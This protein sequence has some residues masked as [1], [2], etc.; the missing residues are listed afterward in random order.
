[1]RASIEGDNVLKRPFSK[2]ALGA[3]GLL[4]FLISGFAGLIYQSIWSQYLGLYL[5]HA[6]YAQCLV[7]AIFMG[8]MA[9]GAWWISRVGHSWRNLLR[10]YAGAELLIGL[11]AWGFNGEYQL[12]T[13]FAY[14]HA[15]PFLAST[16]AVN[17]FKWGSGALL[18]LPQS[19][20][21]GM[22]FPLMSGALMRRLSSKEGSILSGLYF[23]NSMGAAIGALAATFLL[24]PALGLP[25]TIRIGAMLNVA[26]AAVAWIL[27]AGSGAAPLTPTPGV[28]E[29][30]KHD[31][32]RIML[33]AAFI[34]GATS[35]VYEIGWIRML[36][37]ALGT[38]IHSFELMLTAFIVGLAFGGLWIRRRIDSYRDPVAVGGY[39]QVL[40][41]MAALGS[42]FLY[43]RSFGWV[44]WFMHA[45]S[46]DDSGY[47]LYNVV[48]AVI[49]ILIMMPAAFFAGM[50]LPLFTL[51][52]IRR[53]G[54]EASIGRIYAADTLGAIV[55][56]FV[57]MYLLIPDFG[58]KLAIVAGAGGDILLGL[59]LLRSA[60]KQDRLR[61][62]YATMATAFIAVALALVFVRF[63]LGSLSAGVYRTGKAGIDRGNERVIYYR[64]GR[65]STVSVI[66]YRE[67]ARVISTNGKPDASIEMNPGNSPTD[68]EITMV[69][70]GALP[71]GYSR[72]PEE[73]ANIGFGS[74]LTTQTLLS[75][76]RVRDVDSIEIE[77][78]MYEGAKAFI[79]VVDKAY[80][81]PRS[82]IYFDDAKT[83]FAARRKRYDV[84]VSEPSN[85]W[86]TG[87]ATLFS[88][89]FYS[90]VPRYLNRG[91]IFVQWMQLYE[92]DDA[93]V[94]TVINSLNAE[95]K[96]YR[97]Y[98]TDDQDM[99][100]VASADGRL[101]EMQADV[102]DAPG[103]RSLL[104]RV[105]LTGVADF[106]FHELGD[107][108]SMSPLAATL[109]NR[110]NSDFYPVLSLEAPRTRFERRAAYAFAGLPLADLPYIESLGKVGP[111]DPGEVTYNPAYRR[112]RLFADAVSVVSHLTG[113][114]GQTGGSPA[115]DQDAMLARDLGRCETALDASTGTDLLLRLAGET[116]PYLPAR[117][118][119]GVWIH[120]NWWHCAA[121]VAQIR[122]TMVLLDEFA[123]RD[124]S[125]G[126]QAQLILR[127][128]RSQLSNY[129][130]DYLLRIAMLSA[131]QQRDYGQVRTLDQQLGVDIKP[132]DATETQRA[133]LIA[134]ADWALAATKPD[135]A[136]SIH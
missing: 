95:F 25:G 53:G 114:G 102:L 56:V 84:I 63:D 108:D 45:L 57:A 42:L 49:A 61:P 15:F 94:A 122:E 10:A 111:F 105:G 90:Y 13:D 4:L 35:F 88:R 109:S 54:G 38:T 82:H 21:L 40:M 33:I 78:A 8:G 86:V 7:L 66:E 113:H 115:V 30:G 130:A 80:T 41:G 43:T 9:A 51:V 107:K 58:L 76:P 48:T 93:L 24:L 133:Y 132:N 3:G 67:G 75:D 135:H 55:G 77:P 6:A 119:Q 52:M 65:T 29:S 1:M 46:R 62:Y 116:I 96:D 22:T 16:W 118:M 103:L 17:A 81:D 123:R 32:Q 85:P 120:P 98:L 99:V 69:M 31:G 128:Y 97:I 126:G 87:V 2:Q 37:L 129:A 79:P 112:T 101:P 26:I 18:M 60:Q 92:I 27:S 100:V 59:V 72:N 134:Y 28:L 83:Y 106:R 5:G 20:L 125:A 34:T 64:D 50:T 11:M 74:G 117:A 39:V 14:N 121:P 12:I 104:T 110:S 124:A 71:L 91:G 44:E 70:A 131:I 36:N 47:A 68:D 19:I 136:A 89:E 73:V 127:S 23:T